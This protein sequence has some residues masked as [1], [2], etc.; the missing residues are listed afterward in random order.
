MSRRAEA[1][2]FFRQARDQPSDISEHVE[3]MRD[4]ALHCDHIT[5]F[6]VRAGVSTA[7]WIAARPKTLVCYDIQRCAEVDQLSR[8]AR[9]IGIDFTFHQQD[10]LKTTI[11]RTDLLFI[12]TLHTYDQLQAEL[13][14][15]AARVRR[16]IVLHDTETFGQ[17][18]E[19]PGTRGLW[20]A[21]EEYL[22]RHPEWHLL[23]RRTNNNGLTILAKVKSR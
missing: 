10:V 7:A 21:V 3:R 2:E 17:I 23:E 16:Y 22:A 18:G 9:R 6:G 4:L 8:V 14:R 20:F 13:E 19:M 15:H 5:E 12:D 11:D 1:K